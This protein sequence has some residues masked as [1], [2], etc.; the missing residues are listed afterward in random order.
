MTEPVWKNAHFSAVNAFAFHHEHPTRRERGRLT[1]VVSKD[2]GTASYRALSDIFS[3][4][5]ATRAAVARIAEAS[6]ANSIAQQQL[7]SPPPT[8]VLNSKKR[9][10]NPANVVER[11]PDPVSHRNTRRTRQSTTN[12][13]ESGDDTPH[14][15]RLKR[16]TKDAK[17]SEIKEEDGFSDEEGEEIDEPK[18]K[19][20]EKTSKRK[21][22]ATSYAT[23]KKTPKKAGPSDATPKKKKHHGVTIGRSPYPNYE[24][25]TPEECQEVCNR[26]EKIYGVV[27]VPT[28]APTPSLT[29][30]GCGNVPSVL[31]A[32]I[33]TKLSAATTN[34]NADKALSGLKTLGLVPKGRL[35]G[36]G[37]V[38]YAKVMATSQEDIEDAIRQGGLAKMKSKEIKAILSQAWDETTERKARL[39]AG[40]AEFADM[41]DAEKALISAAVDQRMP[42]LDHYNALSDQDALDA[43]TAYPGIGVKTA[44]CVMC[45]CMSRPVF[46]VDT[47]VFRMCKWLGWV[48]ESG[49]QPGRQKAVDEISTFAHCDA[50]IPAAL[51]YK[52]HQ[53]LITHGKRCVRCNAH[54][55]TERTAGWDDGCV[56]EDLVKRVKRGD[57]KIVREPVDVAEKAGGENAV[58]S[59]AKAV[60]EET[61]DHLKTA[62]EEEGERIRER[63]PDTGWK[64]KV[65]GQRTT[66]TWQNIFPGCTMKVKESELRKAPRKEPGVCK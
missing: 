28:K 34:A 46:A 3:M 40:D 52:L 41:T 18:K 29:R 57:G 17:P 30:A 47:H 61:E 58:E 51:K 10:R 9:I 26:L 13:H 50:R 24:H 14:P 4:A 6:K 7:S 39:D 31:D 19:T 25:P 27:K 15:K 23:P 32:M 2:I 37:S 36:E 5:R 59:A 20:P 22:A 42:C 8:P 63:T 11:Q 12:I 48:P 38:D 35:L 66:S 21:S 60:A 33:R 54:V 56:L 53:L 49:S 62:K 64:I 65:T 44:A 55:T 43:M 16:F 45:F 1:V